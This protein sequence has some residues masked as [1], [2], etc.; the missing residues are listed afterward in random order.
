MKRWLMPVAM[1]FMMVALSTGWDARDAHGASYRIFI[2]SDSALLSEDAQAPVDIAGLKSFYED[3]GH[4]VT[5]VDAAQ[6]AA[7][8]S[9]NEALC[10][11]LVLPYGPKFPLESI[12]NFKAYMADGGKLL[13][14]GGYA[15]SRLNEGEHEPF[16]VCRSNGSQRSALA[17]RYRSGEVRRAHASEAVRVDEDGRRWRQRVRP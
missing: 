11:L 10:D 3:D 13:T 1:L 8:A 15:F 4:T 9:F 17:Y 16:A 2:L 6:L 14:L 5:L 7:Y 12:P